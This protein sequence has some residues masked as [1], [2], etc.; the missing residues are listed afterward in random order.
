M[1]LG[2]SDSRS[3]CNCKKI[4]PFFSEDR[5]V[6]R[7]KTTSLS[8]VARNYS[9]V[10]AIPLATRYSSVK[11]MSSMVETLLTIAP[12]TALRALSAIN[13]PIST[14]HPKVAP[15]VMKAI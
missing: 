3:V 13:L 11:P 10:S 12:P 6:E 1:C 8:P 2:K 5:L 4:T 7:R 14:K 9:M 15:A